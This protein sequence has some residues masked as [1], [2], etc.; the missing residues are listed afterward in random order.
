[1]LYTRARQNNHFQENRE[2]SAM[3]RRIPYVSNE[4]RVIDT[5]P[6]FFSLMLLGWI[7]CASAAAIPAADKT[8]RSYNRQADADRVLI[9]VQAVDSKGRPARRLKKE[10]FRLYEDGKEQEIISFEAVRERVQTS[11]SPAPPPQSEPKLPPKIVLILFD[12]STIPEM[13]F[14]KSRTI[15]TR[16]VQEHMR[17]NDLFAVASWGTSMQMLQNLTGNREEVLAAI[18]RSSKYQ[19]TGGFFQHML[20]S[21]EQINDSLE[22]L[23]GQKSI[24]I[25]GRLGTYTGSDLYEAYNRTLKSARTSNVLYYT[26][27]PGAQMGDTEAAPTSRSGF[28]TPGGL[29]PVTLRSLAAESGGGS[30]LNTNTINEDLDN[31]DRQISNYYILGF[32]SNNPKHDG[33]IRSIKIKTEAK[34]V[35]L[36]HRPSYRDK[37][38]IDVLANSRQEQ[39]LLGVLASPN[40]AA[41]IPIEFR[42]T[43]FQDP[44]GAS[45]VLIN[46]RIRLEKT[47]FRK[48]G[49]QI[50]IDLNMIGVAY[51]ESGSIAARF[52]ETIP[53]RIDA[54]KEQAL[55]KSSLIYRNYFKLRPGK[56]NLKLAISDESNN[57]GYSEQPLVLPALPDQGFAASSLVVADTV[58]RLPDIIRDLPAQLLDPLN[59]LLYSGFRIEPSVSNRIPVNSTAAMMF[60][61]YSLSESIDPLKLVAESK[62]VDEKGKEY[63]LGLIR[64][65]DLASPIGN[66]EA[67]VFLRLSFPGVPPGK[68]TLALDA[69]YE[70]SSQRTAL[71][72]DIEFVK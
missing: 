48:K 49:D 60:R 4:L 58:T 7:L 19:N 59:P 13:Y 28:S 42:P 62:L 44:P 38:P 9:E 57:F 21:L 10:D 31:L 72:A 23:R 33:G 64:L 53:V 35:S 47:V 12:D 39:A 16:Y 1:M 30:L 6:V 67:A 14:T 20:E 11:K 27:D 71:Q 8:E 15:A 17:P 69:G 29:M 43:Y 63:P 22:P 25:Y 37:R 52:S 34:G 50:G 70:E 68:Y 32:Q 24:M 54:D 40:N 56:Y 5:L 46:V 41:A 51:S 26:I 66:A 61:I 18:E 3:K 36:K 45:K 65:K 2:E 55:R